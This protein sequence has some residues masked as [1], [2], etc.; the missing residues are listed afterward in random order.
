MH[1]LTLLYFSFNDKGRVTFNFLFIAKS[2]LLDYYYVGAA[3]YKQRLIW[4]KNMRVAS[5]TAEMW[6][7]NFMKMFRKGN[8]GPTQHNENT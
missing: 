2:K 8:W 7:S 1:F 3:I 6:A 5:P 4:D